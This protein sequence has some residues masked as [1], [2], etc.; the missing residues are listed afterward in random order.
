M[1]DETEK[2]EGLN[3]ETSL[4]D[5]NSGN[6]TVSEENTLAPLEDEESANAL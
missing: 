5:A 1:T 4:P 6:P 2:I 3:E